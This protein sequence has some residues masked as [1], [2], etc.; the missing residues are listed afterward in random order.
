MSVIRARGGE[1]SGVPGR[2]W[3]GSGSGS[4]WCLTA[5][6]WAAVSSS[7]SCS[8]RRSAVTCRRLTAVRATPAGNWERM[9]C[10]G[11]GSCLPGHWLGHS[12]LLAG[13]RAACWQVRRGRRPSPPALEGA[14]PAAAEG[15]PLLSSTVLPPD[16]GALCSQES[17]GTVLPPVTLCRPHGAQHRKSSCSVFLVVWKAVLRPKPPLLL[18]TASWNREASYC[19]SLWWDLA[20]GLLGLSQTLKHLLHTRE[21]P[22]P[23]PK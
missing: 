16:S 1:G 2:L 11:L 10:W 4:H 22:P 23:T 14:M 13:L 17:S 18:T 8:H 15:R 5:G 7:K 20:P 3:S 19:Y 12:S 6:A 21:P 9:C